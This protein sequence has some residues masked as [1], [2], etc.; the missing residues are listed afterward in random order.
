[1][2]LTYRQII[3]EIKPS[4]EALN[5]LSYPKNVSVEHHLALAENLDMC[6]SKAKLFWD[7]RKKVLEDLA[8]K[9][10]E[11]KPVTQFNEEL[12]MTELKLS[13]ENK[14]VFQEKYDELKETKVD[15]Q[16]KKMSKKSFNK[17]EGLK[18]AHLRGVILLLKD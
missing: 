6:E 10:K 2:K 8:D 14:S 9:D 16:L 4:L 15:V 13:I 18:P 17:V 7:T 11:G 5:E 1:M 12:K 3:D